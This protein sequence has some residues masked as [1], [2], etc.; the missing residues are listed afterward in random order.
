MKLVMSKSINKNLLC[1][2]E[3]RRFLQNSSTQGENI[4]D[5]GNTNSLSLSPALKS[6]RS[7]MMSHTCEDEIV[8]EEECLK[9]PTGIGAKD[10]PDRGNTP[11]TL[12][13]SCDLYLTP[14]LQA[15]KY[16]IN[17]YSSD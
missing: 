13:K 3:G 12:E 9:T 1:N 2:H 8:E 17:L 5:E 11:S 15:S 10:D 4:Q 6:L 7:R 14:A 16:R